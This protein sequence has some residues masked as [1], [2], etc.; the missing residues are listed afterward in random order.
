[1]ANDNMDIHEGFNDVWVA[2]SRFGLDT[3]YENQEYTPVHG[4]PYARFTITPSDSYPVTMGSGGEDEEIGILFIDLHYPAGAGAGAAYS[5]ADEIMT[6]LK[7]G[8]HGQA[9]G[10]YL[11]VTSVRRSGGRVE[12]G[13]HKVTVQ[14]GYRARKTRPI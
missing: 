13:W 5:K 14:V 12:N 1:M 3:V 4:T 7:V 6:V 10:V 11:H 9:N 8:V 2:S